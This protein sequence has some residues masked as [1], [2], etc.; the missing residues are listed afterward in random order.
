[1]FILGLVA[2]TKEIVRLNVDFLLKPKSP[3]VASTIVLDSFF[4]YVPVE[5]TEIPSGFKIVRL[6]VA[7]ELFT[8]ESVFA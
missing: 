6:N 1:L 2:S 4:L 8:M 5:P 7:V 3:M